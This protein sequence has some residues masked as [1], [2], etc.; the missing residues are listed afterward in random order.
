MSNRKYKIENMKDIVNSIYPPDKG[1]SKG[2]NKLDTKINPPSPL[3][4]GAKN[5]KSFF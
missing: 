1:E 5:P 3:V 4:R 2:V